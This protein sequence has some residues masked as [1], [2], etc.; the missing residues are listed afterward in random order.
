LFDQCGLLDKTVFFDRDKAMKSYTQIQDLPV[1]CL[2]EVLLNELE[3]SRLPRHCRVQ[4]ITV[5][6]RVVQGSSGI[7]IMAARVGSFR[8]LGRGK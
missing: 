7:A 6:P 2:N 8:G 1:S 4:E 5:S 3:G